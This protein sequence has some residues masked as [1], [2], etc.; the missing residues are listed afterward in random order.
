[1]SAFV[2]FFVHLS[3]TITFHALIPLLFGKHRTSRR[4]CLCSAS[5]HSFHCRNSCQAGGAER[6]IGASNLPVWSNNRLDLLKLLGR[7]RLWFTGSMGMSLTT[8]PHNRLKFGLSFSILVIYRTY[9]RFCQV[10][11]CEIVLF[12]KNLH[13]C[14]LESDKKLR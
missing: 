9:V 4:S 13:M 12:L 1:M 6:A 2:R 10:I 5:S 7:A 14:S 11:K 8:P 3:T